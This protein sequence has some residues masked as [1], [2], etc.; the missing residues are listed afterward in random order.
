MRCSL[1]LIDVDSQSMSCSENHIV[2]QTGEEIGPQPSKKGR[3]ELSTQTET[4]PPCQFP[5]HQVLRG[6][7]TSPKRERIPRNRGV[8]SL[9]NKPKQLRHAEF[10]R[11]RKGSLLLL[12]TTG[13]RQKIAVFAVILTIGHKTA[14]SMLRMSEQLPS[15]PV[16]CAMKA[17]IIVANSVIN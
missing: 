11:K 1:A 3:S 15:L 7:G 17:C 10:S 4:I 16:E 6:K 2:D 12:L 5:L 8:S 13:N 14:A 9:S